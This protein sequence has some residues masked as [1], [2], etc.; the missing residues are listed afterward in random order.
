MML[1]KGSK[2][3]QKESE[4][5]RESLARKAESLEQL[6]LEYTSVREE[7]E[8]LQRD[9]IEKERHNQELTEE[10]CSS[11]QELSRVQE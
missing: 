1:E 5:L 3:K 2:D 6:Q 10:V 9:I 7:N 11:R 4:K 8:R